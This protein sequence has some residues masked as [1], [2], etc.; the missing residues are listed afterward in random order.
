[1]SAAA[2]NSITTKGWA[3]AAPA[4]RSAS[5]NKALED[6]MKA[7]AKIKQRLNQRRGA[8][9]VYFIVIVAALIGFC[10][11]GVDFAPVELAKTELQRAADA[12]AGAGVSKLGSTHATIRSEAKKYAAFNSVDGHP[13][14][15]QD[16]DIDI[17]NWNG[18]IFTVDNKGAA[19]RILAR[20]S[21][22]R[23]TA[24][25]LTFAGILGLPSCDVSARAI[26]S[27]AATGFGVIGL[28]YI[29]M[30]GNSSTAYWSTTG[31]T[32]SLRGN[33]A[34]NGDIT[35]SGSSY[36]DGNARPGMGKS[37]IGGSGRVGGS[38]TPLTSPLTYPPGA[39]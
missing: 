35:L 6:V 2:P 26:A 32:S 27:R 10:S 24:V 7:A 30:T 14:V 23:G 39:F 5:F 17:G 12:G 22:S 36:I 3:A 38:I 34:S 1:M 29:D 20:L 21:S 19:V 9:L 25:S 28:D 37:V 15:L 11:L 4:D 18:G 16:V 33:I 8:A 13:L 31:T